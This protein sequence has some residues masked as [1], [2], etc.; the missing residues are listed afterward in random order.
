MESI[1]RAV[2]NIPSNWK[3]DEDRPTSANFK[4][5]KGVS[6]NIRKNRTSKDAICYLLNDLSSDSYNR[7]LVLKE[8]TCIRIE[9]KI[10]PDPSDT[11]EFHALLLNCDNSKDIPSND[12]ISLYLVF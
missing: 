12:S 11:N 1:Y 9:T 8:D 2:K 10:E 5:S 7:V 4:D 6:I 3:G